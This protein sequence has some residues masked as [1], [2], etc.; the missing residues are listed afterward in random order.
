MVLC[1]DCDA[2]M[3][4]Q[5]YVWKSPKGK[6]I[7]FAAIRCAECAASFAHKRTPTV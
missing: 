6:T 7:R 3:I 2:E 5:G 4:A 1:V